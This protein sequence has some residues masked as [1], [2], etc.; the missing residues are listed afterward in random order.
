[1]T[2]IPIPRD[3]GPLPPQTL[4]ANYPDGVTVFPTLSHVVRSVLFLDYAPRSLLAESEPWL[5]TDIATITSQR[6]APL[7]MRFLAEN[8]ICLPPAQLEVLRAAS[9]LATSS[10]LAILD[11]TLP[12]LKAITDSSIPFTVTKGPGTALTCRRPRERPY[13]DI[14]VLVSRNDFPTVVRL[15][16]SYGYAEEPRNTPPWPWFDRYCREALNLRS[17]EGG[18]IDVHHD[19]PPWLWTRHLQPLALISRSEPR[20]IGDVSLPLLTPAYNLLVTALHII[21]D[22][23][24]PGQTLMVWRDVVTIAATTDPASVVSLARQHRILGWLRWI[25]G[26]LPEDVRPAALWDLLSRESG[27]IP[28]TARLKLLLPPAIG[29]QHMLGQAFRLPL[30]NAA[31]YLLG[32]TLPSRRFLELHYGQ[33]TFSYLHWWRDSTRRLASRPIPDSPFSQQPSYLDSR[34]PSPTEA[35]DHTTS[36]IVDSVPPQ[37]SLPSHSSSTRRT[38][39]A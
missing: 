1:M 35:L 31:S 14:D 38:R 11:A 5:P 13:G 7:A 12:A 24:R 6:L 25:I 33:S 27:N 4:V 39:S 9:F 28:S 18:S 17:P 8:N 16:A 2:A 23:N 21:S 15:L 34:G 30:F 36:S 37:T 32:M 29:S 26:Q 20:S 3:T 10:T 19:I 22:H